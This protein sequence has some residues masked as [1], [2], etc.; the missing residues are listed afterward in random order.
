MQKHYEKKLEKFEFWYLATLKYSRQIGGIRTS[1]CSVMLV[2]GVTSAMTFVMEFSAEDTCFNIEHYF[3]SKFY[4]TVHDK[5]HEKF[6]P[7][8]ALNNAT[9]LRVVK[10]FQTNHIVS[11][12]RGSGRRLLTRTPEM[13]TE[14]KEQVVE[15]PSISVRKLAASLPGTSKSS[16]HRT[17][18]D[19]KLRAYSLC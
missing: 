11:R 2:Y 12:K 15:N 16:V 17:L 9:T 13:Q 5:F 10:R 6:G 4:D 18:H 1:T 14:V 7:T 8:R 3:H 19:L